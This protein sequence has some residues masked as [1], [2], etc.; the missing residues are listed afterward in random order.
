MKISLECVQHKI[1]LG[2]VSNVEI[3]NSEAME[4]GENIRK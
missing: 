2:F 3:L 1:C 4:K